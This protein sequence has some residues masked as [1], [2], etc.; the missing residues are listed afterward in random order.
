MHD[1]VVRKRYNLE[2][3]SILRPAASYVTTDHSRGILFL[4][5][6]DLCTNQIPEFQ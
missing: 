4:T 1:L 5:D 3:L 6:H 2:S